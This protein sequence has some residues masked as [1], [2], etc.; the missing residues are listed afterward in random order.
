MVKTRLI[1][2]SKIYLSSFLISIIDA[3]LQ[4]TYIYPKGCIALKMRTRCRSCV[5]VDFV[6][7]AMFNTVAPLLF[8]D[9]NPAGW[10]NAE[11]LGARL[12]DTVAVAS[13]FTLIA[14]IQARWARKR[15]ALNHTTSPTNALTAVFF[16]KTRACS[17]FVIFH[18]A[19]TIV[20]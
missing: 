2:C 1:D 10:A 9:A 17:I 12:A 14:R 16:Y 8:P 3:Y 6:I 11:A 4:T 20:S 19:R 18:H 5:A 15:L 7:G 13:L